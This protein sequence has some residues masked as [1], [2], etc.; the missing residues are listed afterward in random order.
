MLWE[1]QKHDQAIARADQAL[2]RLEGYLRVEPN[3]HEARE[4]CLELH[5]NR[6]QAFMAREQH[7][8]AAS[9]W[10]RV[11]EL[12]SDP[13]PD[14][15]RLVLAFELLKS[16]ELERAVA[17]AQL[18]LQSATL[19]GADLYNL[20]CFFS[21]AAVAVPAAGGANN[22]KQ[23]QRQASYAALALAALQ[24]AAAAGFFRDDTA[25]DHA[26]KD[27]D[28]QFVRQRHEFRDLLEVASACGH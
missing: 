7:K 10:A 5:G 9:D 4:I 19:S 14:S 8:E 12:S 20:G 26:R 11:V 1:T 16:G 23:V 28:L 22:A 27:P 24:K 18:A 17:A 13:V 3:D 2:E 6:A 21:R 15:Y 25:R